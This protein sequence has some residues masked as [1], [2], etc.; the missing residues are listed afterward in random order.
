MLRAVRSDAFGTA[1]R[2]PAWRLAAYGEDAVITVDLLARGNLT[3][4]LD[5]VQP[6]TVFDC[7][8]YGAY[9][10]EQ[11]IERMYQTNVVFKQELIER[12]APVAARI[13]TFTPAAPPNT[14]RAPP[15]PTKTTPTAPNSHYAVTKNAAA[16]LVYFC[17][18]HRGLRCANLRLYSVYGPLEDRS[19][20]IPTLVA[21]AAEQRLPPFVDPETS[22]DFV[23][24]DD[25]VRAFLCAAVL[26][27]PEHYGESFNV[28]SGRKTTIR[29][30]AQLAKR[31]FGIAAEPEFSS[32]P[33]RS[34]DLADWYANPARAAEILGWRARSRA[35]RGLAPHRPWYSALEDVSLYERASKKRAARQRLQRQRRHRLLQ[36]RPGDPHHGRAAGADVHQARHRLRNHLRERRQSGRFRG[37]DPRA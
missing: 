17:G 28:G 23:Y 16:G 30:L 36:G 32:M 3:A 26:L 35:R 15:V 9:P 1:S 4:L 19:R 14:A 24:I 33:A 18:H 37:G 34:W 21:H 25:A 12:A 22:R 5:R 13:A 31:E 8:A 2:E 7:V 6:A 10:F 29:E 27:R 20:L 11:D